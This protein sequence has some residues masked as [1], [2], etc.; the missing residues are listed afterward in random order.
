MFSES[1]L[2][3]ISALQHLVF[4]ERQCALIHLE[5]LWAENRLTAEGRQLHQWVDEP[6]VASRTDVRIARG[7]PLACYRLGLSGRAD[8]VEFHQVAEGEPG[9]LLPG[10]AGLWQPVPV[11][12]KRG[13][14]KKDG[15]D[16]VQLCAQVLALEEML[17][18][19]VP[20][21]V[22]FYGQTRRRVEVPIAAAL[23]AR[24]ETL[25]ARM[26]EIIRS[27]RTPQVKY[28]KKCDNCS[29][30]ELCLPKVTD[31]RRSALRYLRHTSANA[32]S[33]PEQ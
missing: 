3:P 11:E 28:E 7:V 10:V 5:G 29:L 24:T 1:D 23:R 2:L 32:E 9:T 12:Y 13:R 25:A 31:G 26:H 16:E 21:G 33:S 20:T 14:P 22:L 17:A 18:T 30:L 27:G 8:I 6:G 15:S 19:S 4:C